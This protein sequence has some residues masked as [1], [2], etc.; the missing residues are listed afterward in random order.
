[1]VVVGDANRLHP[2]IDDGWANELEP[3][4]S[5]SLEMAADSGV[6]TSKMW[7]L[8]GSPSVNDQQ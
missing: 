1:M 5:I 8:I 4:L 2:R 7:P 3:A 6:C